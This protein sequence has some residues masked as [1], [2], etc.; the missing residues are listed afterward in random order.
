MLILNLQMQPF[1]LFVLRLHNVGFVKSVGLK[2]G[3]I[4]NG[5][6]KV[7][8]Y[9]DCVPPAAISSTILQEC[10]FHFIET[11]QILVCQKDKY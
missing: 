2:A 9:H 3:Y 10:C 1:P 11:L 8:N 4:P 7:I 6:S 5:N